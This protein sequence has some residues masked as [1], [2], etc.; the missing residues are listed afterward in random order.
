MRLLL[1][2]GLAAIVLPEI[3]PRRAAAI[4]R[5]RCCRGWQNPASR[6]PWRRCLYPQ[7]DAAGADA[8]CQRWRLSN[9]ETDRTV[10]LVEHHA[11]LAG[12]R[13]MRWSAVQPILI[14]EGIEDLL[15]LMDAVS[16]AAAE[17]AAYCRSLQDRPREV[18]DPP[19]LL[20]GDDLLALGIPAG[21]RYKILLQQLRD[22][23]LDGEIRTKD[24]AVAMAKE[25]MR[26]L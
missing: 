10:W 6:W 1:E 4:D 9:K 24:E 3:V 18:L 23:Q 13:A 20:T 8:V 16:P 12:A 2:I 14:S 19:P 21:P 22:A 15:A 5:W 26:R 25:D 17:A 11:A 7:V